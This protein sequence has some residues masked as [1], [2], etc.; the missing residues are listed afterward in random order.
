MLIKHNLLVID[1]NILN[2]SEVLSKRHPEDEEYDQFDD[3]DTQKNGVI[4]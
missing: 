2:D 1:G 3:D 4:T